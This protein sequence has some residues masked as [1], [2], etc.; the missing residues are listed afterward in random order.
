MQD[1]GLFGINPNVDFWLVG[2]KLIGGTEVENVGISFD[3]VTLSDFRVNSF[4]EASE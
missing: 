3:P 4:V 2:T 1:A